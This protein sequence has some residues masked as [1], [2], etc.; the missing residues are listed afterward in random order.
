MT[1]QLLLF[2]NFINELDENNSPGHLDQLELFFEDTD[3]LFNSITEIVTA[4]QL[5]ITYL[6][7]NK[8][9]NLQSAKEN[10][11]GYLL[12]WPDPEY[13]LMTVISS[14]EKGSLNSL[15]AVYPFSSS[16]TQFTC[17]LQEIRLFSNK[18]EAQL[19]VTAGEDDLLELTFYDIHFLYDQAIYKKDA[20]YRF[21]LRAFAYHVEIHKES[22]SLSAL[23]QRPDLGADHYEVQGQVI[24]INE[25]KNGML[26]QRTWALKVAIAEDPCGEATALE[27]LLSAKVLGNEKPPTAGQGISAVIWLQGHLWGEITE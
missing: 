14:Q 6:T 25:L 2:N 13:G 26:K 12:K 9:E 20:Q 19:R 23:F 24:A 21:I 15:T 11:E 4:S 18:I 10:P 7:A 16:G 22:E 1:D 27:I 17:R 8:E 3:E 5:A